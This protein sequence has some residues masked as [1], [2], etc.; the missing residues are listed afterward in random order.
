MLKFSMARY[1]AIKNIDPIYCSIDLNFI[2]C[3]A[4]LL[5]QCECDVNETLCERA[6]FSRKRQFVRAILS[7]GYTPTMN[8]INIAVDNRDI[9]MVECLI[10]NGCMGSV[11][12]CEAAAQTNQ[13]NIL[14]VL[15]RTGCSTGNA[16]SIAAKHNHISCLNAMIMMGVIIT[17]HALILSICYRRIEFVKSIR[18]QRKIN[19]ALSIYTIA[20]SLKNVQCL[21]YL[22]R[23]GCGPD[24]DS[25]PAAVASGDQSCID[26]IASLL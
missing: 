24:I 23:L 3:F 1:T 18:T 9:Y 14:V 13:P 25:L 12:S 26:H 19:P 4:Y 10:A 21:Q 22:D 15:I 20:S 2:D 8:L 16:A 11:Q 6:V 5:N 7:R 17:D